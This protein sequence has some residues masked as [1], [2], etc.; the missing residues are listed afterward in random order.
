MKTKDYLHYYIGQKCQLCI[1]LERNPVYETITPK[2]VLD[3]FDNEESTVK[4][5]LRKVEDMTEEEGFKIAELTMEHYLNR[6]FFQYAFN[7]LKFPNEKPSFKFEKELYDTDEKGVEYW[8]CTISLNGSEGGVYVNIWHDFQVQ[9]IEGL[10]DQASANHPQIFH[11]LLQ[12]GFDIFGLINEGLA[13]DSK[14][15]N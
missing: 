13:I 14:K 1:N 2:I 7:F 6:A 5:I 9:L 11:Y 8:K 15:I 10:Q 12:Q 4:P 3:E